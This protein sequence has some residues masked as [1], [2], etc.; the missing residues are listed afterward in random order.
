MGECDGF[1]LA[2]KEPEVDKIKIRPS[3][4]QNIESQLQGL[5]V[6]KC[7]TPGDSVPAKDNESCFCAYLVF[8]PFAYDTR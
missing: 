6:S 1:L 8:P 4:A 2:E 7:G 3:K 5:G